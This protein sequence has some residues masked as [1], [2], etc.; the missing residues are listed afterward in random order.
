M[1]EIL[2]HPPGL[3]LIRFSWKRSPWPKSLRKFLNSHGVN[4]VPIFCTRQQSD[5]SKCVPLTTH[6]W[7]RSGQTQRARPTLS[8]ANHP[9]RPQASRFI[10][11]T[12]IAVTNLFD[13]FE[14]ISIRRASDVKEVYEV[15]RYS[16]TD[17]T[18][19]SAF[20]HLCVVNKGSATLT[21][22]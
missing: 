19:S 15:E 8:S 4:P 5:H 11:T 17:R 1:G 14:L 18:N 13:I 9:A 3:W 7:N 21:S 2:G 20:I 6:V 16:V 12:V 10:A 22:L